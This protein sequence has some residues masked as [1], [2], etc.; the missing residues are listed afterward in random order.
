M[1]SLRRPTPDVVRLKA[2]D[3]SQRPF[4]YTGV[5]GTASTPP[6][7]YVVDHTRVLLGKGAAVFEAARTALRRWEQ[8]HFEWLEVAAPETPIQEGAIV[9]VLA[10]L[11]GVWSLNF[12]RIVYVVDE[13]GPMRRFGFAYGT[14]PDHAE[15]GEE[16]FLIEWDHS[17]DEVFYDILAF[18]KPQHPLARLGYPVVR[19]LQ[20]KFGRDSVAAMRRAVERLEGRW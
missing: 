6:A 16:R 10:R 7:G 17:S 18:S 9:P 5:S 12:C 20:K 8:F 14:L 19:R 3:Q 1:I 4:T 13:T 11:L 15:S 2:V